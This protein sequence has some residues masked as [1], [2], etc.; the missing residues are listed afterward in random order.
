MNR[1]WPAGLVD[2]HV[3]TAPDVV[4]RSVTDSQLARAVDEA[5]YRA[6]VLKS[7]HTVTATR[8]T[9]AQEHAHDAQI[10]GGAVLN[11]QS[12]GGVNPHAVETVLKLGGRVIWLPTITS[13]NQIRHAA[14]KGIASGSLKA[15]GTIEGPGLDMLDQEGRPTADVCRVLDLIAGAGATLATGHIGP[16]E[17]MQVVPEA[18]RR[19]VPNVLITHPEHSCVGLGL[20]QQ[21]ELAELGGVWFERVF[22]ITLPTSDAVPLERVAEAIRTVGVDSTVMATDFG[23]AHNVSPIVGFQQYIDAMRD[24]GFSQADI[25]AMTV[26]NPT[27]ALALDGTPGVR[28]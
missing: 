5:G 6:V 10:L 22:V 1:T 11:V 12:T 23:Q 24:R 28:A 4:P 27:A 21:L 2:T 9:M 20:D 13:A 25:E 3:H 26:A 16:A 18:R 17:I 8:A 14:E 7:H 15:L 19:G